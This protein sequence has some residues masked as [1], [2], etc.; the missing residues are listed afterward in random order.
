MVDYLN[1]HQ[2]GHILTVEDP[3]EFVHTSKKSLVNQREVGPMTHP[4]LPPCALPCV[5]TRTAF[6]SAKCVT[7]KPFAWP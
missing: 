1:S 5:K 3:I 7:W 4:S 2:H 6:W